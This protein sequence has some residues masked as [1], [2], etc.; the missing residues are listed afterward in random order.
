MFDTP[1]E[2]RDKAELH[3]H[4]LDYR[5]V[6]E[7]FA[8]DKSLFDE[9]YR[10]RKYVP[11][12]NRIVGVSVDFSGS[13]NEMDTQVA[14]TAI[15]RAAQLQGD[16]FTAAG[17][18]TYAGGPTDSRTQLITGPT[19]QFKMEHNSVVSAHGK[20]PLAN[21]VDTTHRLL[22]S[23][24][25]T[26]KIMF[27]I[28]DGKP[29]RSMKKS[30]WPSNSVASAEKAIEIAKTNNIAVIGFG[31][32]DVDE[33]VMEKLFGHDG[34]VMTDSDD[35]AEELLKTYNTKCSTIR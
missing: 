26:E 14:L 20:T 10:N 23:N 5:N 15:A 17:F 22:A 9:L 12:G 8:G 19:E 35:L 16:N 6:A 7:F 29:N 31:V 33:D 34:Y 13:V 2:L 3:G 25:A 24:N 18:T 4:Q 32:D 1:P 27:V 11:G 28:T 21:G 30:D